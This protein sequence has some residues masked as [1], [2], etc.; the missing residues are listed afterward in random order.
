MSATKD[1]IL[2]SVC[3]RQ[4]ERLE[5]EVVKRV[6]KPIYSEEVDAFNKIADSIFEMLAAAAV[7][8]KL[9]GNSIQ[10]AIE[11]RQNISEALE[12]NL[13]RN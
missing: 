4:L 7:R 12:W 9:H 11:I 8:Q 6:R 13:T 10:E 2:Y 5:A 1:F 3:L